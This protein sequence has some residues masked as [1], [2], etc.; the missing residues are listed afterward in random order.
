MRTCTVFRD[1]KRESVDPENARELLKTEGARLWLDVADPSDDDLA[2][3]GDHFGLHR[4]SLEDMTHRDQRPRVETFEKYTFVAIRPLSRGADSGDLTVHEIHAVVGTE[5]LVTLCYPPLYDLGSVGRRLDDHPDLLSATSAY[6]LYVLLD[7]VADDFLDIVDRFEQEV[8]SL[9]GDV[10]EPPGGIVDRAD[11]RRRFHTLRVNLATFR[12]HV[13][14]MRRAVDSLTEQQDVVPRDLLPYYRDVA[15]HVIRALEF[16]DNV[17]DVLTS[18]IEVRVAQEA[19]ELNEIMK[20]LTAWAG[21]I[22]VPTLIAGIYGM[23]FEHMPE[24]SWW[25]GYPLSLGLMALAALALFVMFKKR[26]WL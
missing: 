25:V 6:M 7:E 18:L 16:A 5:F 9:E 24:L 15:D 13:S 26:G 19:N 8:E 14:P 10:F 23:N 1:G 12:R 17:R 20:K 11:L 22:L 2:Y 4:L 3:L 21:I